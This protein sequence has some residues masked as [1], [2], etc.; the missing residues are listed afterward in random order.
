MKVLV[1]APHMDDEVLGV[2]GTIARHVSFGDE[3][4]VCFAAH[5]VYEH[6]Y[7]EEQNQAEIQNAL[8]ARDQNGNFKENILADHKIMEK[9]SPK[10]I[11]RIFEVKYH[12]KNVDLIFKRVFKK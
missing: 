9:V 10:E 11:E 7:N 8:R 1:I 5:R 2:G 6:R 12:L 4:Y 3:V